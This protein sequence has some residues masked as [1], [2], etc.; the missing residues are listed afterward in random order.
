MAKLGWALVLL[1]IVLQAITLVQLFE[2]RQTISRVIELEEST[3]A[4]KNEAAAK[5][6]E[7]ERIR[8]VYY[9]SLTG[10]PLVLTEE[11]VEEIIKQGVK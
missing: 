6:L 10:R 9:R 8:N 3:A 1:L 4:L 2:D 11:Q 5:E 7:T